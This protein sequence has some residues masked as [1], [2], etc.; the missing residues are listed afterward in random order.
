MRFVI[1]FVRRGNQN[2]V[3]VNKNIFINKISENVI[4]EALKNGGTLSKSKQKDCPFE[5]T[6]FCPEGRLVDVFML[7]HI[8]VDIEHTKGNKKTFQI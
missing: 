5:V 3:N 6:R 2:I 7:I 8:E 4:H 1:F